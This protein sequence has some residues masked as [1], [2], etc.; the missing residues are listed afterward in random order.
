MISSTEFSDRTLFAG[1]QPSRFSRLLELKK[2]A[3][4]PLW[5]LS[6]S[7]PTRCG[8]ASLEPRLLESL[9][10]PRNLGYEP[11][12]QGLLEAREAVCSYYADKGVAVSPEQVFLT[13]STSEA[14]TYLFHLL[15]DPADEILCVSP[16]Y[17]LF[18]HLG[19]MADVK[20]RRL[21]TSYD[22]G[23][24]LDAHKIEESRGPK[25]KA[26]ILV[27]PNNPTGHYPQLLE[28]SL[29]LISDE[30]FLDFNLQGAAP[31]GRGP[32]SAASLGQTLTFTLSGVS[33]I[34]GLPQ[35]KLSWIVVSGPKEL[36]H[37]ACRRLEF[38]AD[39]Y[40]SVNTPSQ[41]ALSVWL[42]RRNLFIEEARLRIL[43]NLKIAEEILR[44]SSPELL[45]P[46]GGWYALLRL[47]GRL[48]DEE[49]A[50]QLL[51]ERDVLVHPGFFF[52]FEE[53]NFLVLSLLPQ[54]SVFRQG[55]ERLRG[56]NI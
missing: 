53:E 10:D 47:H 40:L 33:K 56:L 2:K 30:V 42:E 16:G 45:R 5:D 7:N 48:N 18:D 6:E 13:S 39:A 55:M 8:F 41:R 11:D 15:A 17:P 46:Q 1:G 31:S 52:D 44:G 27:N 20:L 21:H 43:S 23:W 14:Y 9:R 36:R 38:I 28:G 12:P 19:C 37:E 26:L 24:E 3:G 29:P 22:Q 34:L 54:E 35:M 51:Q 50:I 32:K 25:T 4:L 49:A